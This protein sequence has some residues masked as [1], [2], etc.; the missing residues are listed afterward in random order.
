MKVIEPSA[1]IER[2]P[3]YEDVLFDV[4]MATRTCYK[5]E[6]LGGTKE[7]AERVIR[8]CLTAEPAPHESVIEHASVTARFIISRAVSHE[9]VRHRIAAISQESQRYCAYNKGKFGGEVTFIRPCFFGDD[10]VTP[11]RKS[12]WA[13]ACRRAEEAYFALLSLGAKPEEAREVLPNSTKTEV[14]FSANLREW[15]HVFK[16]RCHKA[17]HPSMRQVMRPLFHD[18][19]R[20]YPVFFEDMSFPKTWDTEVIE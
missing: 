11:S 17:A 8:K 3:K 10:H 6:D 14:V 5:S 2:G 4:E 7:S 13:T 1:V 20:T 15:R 9:L 19:K 12:E 16:L 18:F